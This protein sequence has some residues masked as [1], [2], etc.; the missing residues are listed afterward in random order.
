MVT[1]SS[2][3]PNKDTLGERN[4]AMA[5]DEHQIIAMKEKEINMFNESNNKRTAPIKKI[6]ESI[7]SIIDNL[8]TISKFKYRTKY[9][10]NWIGFELKH[11]YTLC[12]KTDFNGIILSNNCGIC[13]D[14]KYGVC[15]NYLTDR[16]NKHAELNYYKVTEYYSLND[17]ALEMVIENTLIGRDIIHGLN[18][19]GS[20][21]VKRFFGLF[22]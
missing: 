5:I 18:K 7:E 21:E 13:E 14:D 16:Y 8:E 9:D 15:I 19:I 4:N 1:A 12:F 6:W 10:D 11:P 2:R 22:G 20:N 17:K 3:W